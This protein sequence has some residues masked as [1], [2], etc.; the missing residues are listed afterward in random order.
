MAAA[1]AAE[2]RRWKARQE[3]GGRQEG[4]RRKWRA[5]ECAEG[6]DKDEQQQGQDGVMEASEAGGRWVVLAS[7]DGEVTGGGGFRR[8]EGPL[9]CC[10]LR[11]RGRRER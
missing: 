10:A 9:L 3:A 6:Q 7:P 2:E 8:A 1:A 4:G 11:S 5:G